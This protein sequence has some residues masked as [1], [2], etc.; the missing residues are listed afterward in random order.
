[1]ESEQQNDDKWLKRFLDVLDDGIAFIR[2]RT[3]FPVVKILRGAVFGT[4]G[5]LGAVLVFIFM[6]LALFRGMNELLDL[7]WS[8]ETAVW[9][10]Y[11]VIGGVFLL[12]G[13]RLMRRRTP[14]D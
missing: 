1:M 2:E 13:S 14:R 8:R 9:A 7:W 12:I 10:S 3:T 11:L 6:L 4:F 5:V